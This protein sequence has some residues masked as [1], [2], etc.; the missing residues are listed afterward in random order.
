MKA[1]AYRVI[2]EEYRTPLMLDSE[3]DKENHEYHGQDYGN[4]HHH[5]TVNHA[6]GSLFSVPGIF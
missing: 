5:A 2:L 3:E 1:F 6:S 4:D